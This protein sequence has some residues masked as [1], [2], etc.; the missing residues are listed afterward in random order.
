MIN[1]SKEQIQSLIPLFQ[2]HIA[3]ELEYAYRGEA[4]FGHVDIK[5]YADNATKPET[6]LFINGFAGTGLYGDA[7]NYERNQEIKRLIIDCFDEEEKEVWL[8]LYSPEWEPVVDNLFDGYSSWK[9]HR[10]IHRLNGES[11]QQR[12]SWRDK[13]PGGYAMVKV[14]VSSYEFVNCRYPSFYWKPEGNKFGWFLLKDGE[15]VSECISVWVEKFGVE[16][17][18]VEI[19]IE[20]KEEYRRKGYAALTATAF[21]ED[22]LSQKLTPVWCCWS[23]REGSKELA[24]MLGFEIIEER[25]AIFLKKNIERK[26][27]ND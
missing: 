2:C 12:S 26:T 10:L 14:D 1:L 21:V 25:R 3:Q 9:A 18:C 20:T 22:C 23:F 7:S 17:N 5:V 27:R 11:F 4:P 15:V 6:M 19:G 8:S 16:K 24:K 13:I